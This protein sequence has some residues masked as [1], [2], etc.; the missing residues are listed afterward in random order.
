MCVGL[1]D[2]FVVCCKIFYFLDYRVVVDAAATVISILCARIR[3]EV[4]VVVLYLIL[5]V[6][7]VV[8]VVILFVNV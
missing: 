3:G 1:R 7:I 8:N 2:I 4:L 6:F 5:C